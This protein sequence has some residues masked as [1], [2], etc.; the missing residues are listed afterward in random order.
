MHRL[1][2]A[3]SLL[4]IVHAG[5]SA[6]LIDDLENFEL[7]LQN[8]VN[9]LLY[10]SSNPDEPVEIYVND[11]NGTTFDGSKCIKVLI[12]GFGSNGYL[13]WI[14]NMTS[15]FIGIED[16]NVISVDWAKA[17]ANPLYNV[18]RRNTRPVG[19]HLGDLLLF[20]ADNSG[21]DLSTVHCLGHSLGAHVCGYAGKV[22]DGQIGRITGLDPALPLFSFDNAT[23]RLADSDALFVDVIHTCAGLLGFD[24]PIGHVDFYPNGGV[25]KQPGCGFDPTASCSHERCWVFFMESIQS[26]EFRA[27]QCDSWD[28]FL[29]GFC[30]STQQVSMGYPTPSNTRGTFYLATADFPPFALG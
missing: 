25:H 23:E 11:L 28:D 2:I 14:K 9:F 29:A 13:D 19:E 4:Q 24:L 5:L 10:S 22:L 7:D 26:D 12:H 18:A 16:C 8:D 15:L 3:L 20:L 17:A 21:A 6:R 27:A 1:V 30:N